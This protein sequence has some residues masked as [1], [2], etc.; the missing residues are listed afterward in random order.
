MIGT[1]KRAGALAALAAGIIWGFLGPF[2][3]GCEE[4]G[5]TT[6]QMTCLRY[7][8]VVAVLAPFVWRGRRSASRLDRRSILLLAGMG[9]IGIAAN[10]TLYF[11]SMTMIPLSASTVLQYLA[12]FVVVALSIPLFHERRSLAKTAAV[13]VAFTGCV[14]CSGLLSSQGPIDLAGIAFGAASGF[15]F[16]LYTLC[17]KALARDEHRPTEVL[18]YSGLISIVCLAPFCD[19][20]GGVATAA[21][22][23]ES[24]ALLVGLGLGMTLLPFAL[25][26]FALDRIEAG[27][28]SIISFSEPLTAT[29]IGFAMYCEALTIEVVAGMAMIM[30][31]LLAINRDRGVAVASRRRPSGRTRSGCAR[32]RRCPWPWNSH[33]AS[34]R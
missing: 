11:Q 17:S 32:R 14:L 8:V 19:L 33:R 29:A 30:A 6:S 2:V 28:T 13:I 16:A 34:R 3:R 7:I 23:A 18:F 31:A 21:S 25:Y 15:C 9:T 26:N 5:L 12:P 24:M 1:R 4:M 27:K 20:P 22:S 10:S